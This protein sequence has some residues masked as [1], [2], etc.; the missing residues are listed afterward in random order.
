MRSRNPRNVPP[1]NE[2]IRFPEIRLI[3]SDG[4][5]LGIMPPR[6]AMKLAEEKELDLVLV[7]DKASP[8]V[9]RIIDY[10]K[11]KFEQEKR[12]REAR[13]RQHNAEVKE[14]K[15]RYKI[16]DHDYNVRVKNAQRF[17]KSGDKVKAT[18]MFRGREIQHSD[19]AKQLLQRMAKDLE[20]FAE[21]QQAPKQ[22]G[23]NMMMLLTPKK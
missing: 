10:G 7:S 11:Y 16:D 13:K 17:L 5:Q 4:A 6:E 12:A 8:P 9:C 23:R 15:M 1:I 19:L 21:V 18:V 22:E 3:D 2:N 14:V 20:E